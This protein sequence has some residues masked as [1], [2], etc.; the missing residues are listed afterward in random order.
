V[1]EM[2][3]S[4]SVTYLTRQFDDFLFARIDEGSD[5]TPLSVLSMLARLDVDPWEEAAKLARLPRAAAAKRLV[6]FIAATPGAPSAYLNAKTVC[7]RLLNLLPPPVSAGIL[8]H[9]NYGV[10]A[11]KRSPLG[12]WLVVI[13]VILGISLIV[14]TIR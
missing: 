13:A 4:T 3:T 1:I 11:I 8:P 6:D 14:M 2:P 12:T 9:R 10:H 5:A 7:D